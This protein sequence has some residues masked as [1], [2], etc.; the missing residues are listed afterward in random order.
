MLATNTKEQKM[1]LLK[2]RNPVNT[3][4][5]ECFRCFRGKSV[6]EAVEPY[7]PLFVLSYAKHF[8][9]P[10]IKAAR[11]LGE[12]ERS[13]ALAVL[14]LLRSSIAAKGV[15]IIDL[16]RQLDSSR[17]G[18]ISRWPKTISTVLHKVRA[19]YTF[20][21]KFAFFVGS[22][23]PRRTNR[24]NAGPC[25]QS[26]LLYALIYVEYAVITTFACRKHRSIASVLLMTC[27]TKC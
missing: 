5:Q 9:R 26:A 7:F 20:R 27:F 1:R 10:P 24:G 11:R 21:D 15:R 4:I 18:L 6:H 8:R 12:A 25:S 3:L 19:L 2:S 14:S 13:G 23:S 17:D 16:F 22:S